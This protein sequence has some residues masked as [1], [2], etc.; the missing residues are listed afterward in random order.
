[1]LGSGHG[2]REYAIYACLQGGIPGNI[3]YIMVEFSKSKNIVRLAKLTGPIGS[4]DPL[5]NLAGA[6]TEDSFR[7]LSESKMFPR[8]HFTLF[9]NLKQPPTMLLSPRT[10]RTHKLRGWLAV[11]INEMKELTIECKYLIAFELGHKV[12]SHYSKISRHCNKDLNMC[13]S[14]ARHNSSCTSTRLH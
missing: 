5:L 13:A 14:K 9:A 3:P 1:M 6:V 10:A 12:E 8:I 4:G 2:F 11:L 7:P